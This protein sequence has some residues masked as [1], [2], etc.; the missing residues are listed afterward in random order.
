MSFSFDSICEF[1]ACRKGPPDFCGWNYFPRHDHSM[2]RKLRS[3]SLIVL[4]ILIL[5]FFKK[6]AESAE[7]DSTLLGKPIRTIAI[8]SDLPL[9]RSHYDPYLGIK[10]GD[11]MTRT[12]V[13]GAIQFFYECGRFSKVGAEALP[14]GDGVL[15][16]F[17][18]RHN[19]Y[20]NKFSIE[21][22][23]D[24]KGR[25][26]WE[27]TSLPIGQRFTEEMLEES[28]QAVLKFLKEKGFYLSQI[29][30]RTSLDDRTRQVNTI[31]EVRPGS[32]ATIQT[33]GLAGIPPQ[34][35]KDVLKRFGFHAGGPYDR[36]RLN[37]RLENLRKYFLKKGYLAAMAQISESFDPDRNSVSLALSVTNFGKIRVAVEGFKIEKNQLR[38][39]LPILNGEGINPWNLAEGVKN[40]KDYLENKGYSE[41]DVKINETVEASG[42]R[43]LHHQVIPNRRFITGFVHFRGNEALTERELLSSVEI[44]SAN[45]F[46]SAA[47]SRTQL[48]DDVDALKALYESR[49]YLQAEVIPLIEPIQ[50]GRGLGIT[51]LCQEG[52]LSRT[53]SLNIS[54]NKAISTGELTSKIHLAPGRPYS[55][56]LVEQDRQTILAAYND[57]GYIQTQISVRIGSPDK[58][59]SYPVEFQIQEGTQSVVDRILVLGNEQTRRSVVQKKIKLKEGEPLSLSGLL[60][61]Q[62]GLYGL[63]VF[64]QVRVAPQNADSTA[65]YQD[66][67]VRLQESKRFT[68]RYGFGYQEREKLRGT[69]E[70]TDLNILG[71]ARRADIRFRAS[72]IEQQALFNL[73]QPQFRVLPVESYFTFSVLQRRDVSFDSRRFS[74]SYQFSHP[75]GGH[76]WGMLRYNFK[77]VRV[78]N[79]Q[80]P[81]SELG[82]EDEPVNLSTISAAFINDSRD[83]YLDPS[84][85]FFSSTNFGVTTKLL[86]DN[87]YISFF[88][89][90]SYYR[91]LPKSLLL[92]ASVR[93]G[94]AHPY[95]GDRDLPISE[96]FFAGGGSSIR[97]FDTDYAGPL[98]SQA[99]KPVG[100]NVLLIG[101]IEM[102]FPVFSIV[103][104]AGFYD[105]GNVFRSIH[106]VSYS[107]FSHTLGIGLRIK[108]PFGPLRADYGYN[109]NL[110]PDLRQR[111]LKRGHLFITVGPPF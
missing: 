34:G 104:L 88:S 59:Q 22:P 15:L 55:P 25:S 58:E 41:A 68:L 42:V 101:S 56:S 94:A 91:G 48:D 19:Y 45:L 97:G 76:S 27:W 66:V 108:T 14:E 78:L 71:S 47:Y 2:R 28:R 50:E 69:L 38:K 62:Q 39:L 110:S 33:I 29:K 89:Q 102:R 26:L 5:G 21:G 84:K 4:F 20:F 54:G 13:K 96:R 46:Q 16:R 87:D 60:Q 100:G 17:N 31:F 81:I 111:G 43:I 109:L 65:P 67:V 40:L 99:N 107:G 72:S 3:L 1:K 98:D 30:A 52:S 80:V 32:L 70:F 79:S 7:P 103:R 53:S 24:L 44:Q 9:D 11:P 74:L 95:G 23:V 18:L 35:S 75:Y 85:G 10:T 77:N 12:A 93:L 49:G 90:N 106:D 63:G 64:D 36:S 51:Y 92:A 105:T 86:G 83:D 73:Q 57:R 37:T 8:A 82:R 61:S 6:P